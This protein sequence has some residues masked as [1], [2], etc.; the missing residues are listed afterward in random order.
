MRASKPV[1][2]TVSVLGVLVVFGGITVL[3]P[4]VG[5]VLAVAI[6]MLW[7]WW[8]EHHPSADESTFGVWSY[9]LDVSNTPAR[10]R[11]DGRTRK[12]TT[13]VDLRDVLH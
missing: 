4:F 2:V 6:A 1:L 12:T 13:H 3:P 9:R 5:F 10:P 8:L 11:R 7:C